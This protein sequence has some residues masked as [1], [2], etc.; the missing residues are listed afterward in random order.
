MDALLYSHGSVRLVWVELYGTSYKRISLNRTS[1]TQGRSG[2]ILIYEF[3]IK[4]ANYSGD[5]KTSKRIERT[6]KGNRKSKM[7]SNWY[8]SRDL[9]AGF[10]VLVIVI[11]HGTKWRQDMIENQVGGSLNV[12]RQEK[13]NTD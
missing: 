4:A 1:Y 12:R 11:S 9:L 13:T 10:P 6:P 3:K 2:L 8:V 5:E 7:G